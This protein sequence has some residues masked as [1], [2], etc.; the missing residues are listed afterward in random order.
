MQRG[1]QGGQRNETN[2]DFSEERRTAAVRARLALDDTPAHG[3]DAS[4][5]DIRH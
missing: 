3:R 4:H 2:H 5:D 1:R